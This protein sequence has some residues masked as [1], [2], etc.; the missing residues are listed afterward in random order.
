MNV[1]SSEN[2]QSGERKEI[3]GRSFRKLSDYETV[4]SFVL[5]LVA[6]DTRFKCRPSLDRILQ[7][8][9]KLVIVISHSSPLSWLPAPCLL[10]A[11][12]V[13]RGGSGRIPIGVM[14]RF[15]YSVPGL[16]ELAQFIGQSETPLGFDELLHHFQSLEKADLVV[17]PE[18]SNCFFGDPMEL[19]P[20]RSSRFVEIAIRTKTPML[21]CVHRGSESWGKTVPL[22]PDAVTKL[23]LPEMLTKFLGDRL[24]QT[25]LLTIPFPPQPM[26][27]FSM[28]CELYTPAT[29][30]LSDDPVMAKEQIAREAAL[31]HQRM[32]ELLTEIDDSRASATSPETKT[33]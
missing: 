27:L 19:Q 7:E 4:T 24:R 21:L 33:N 25:G 16:K 3:T 5:S 23:P 15:F 14:D 9:A 17:F 11:H 28:L 8:N 22:D 32:R 12:S 31:V 18:G 13:A 1:E 2:G 6:K 29:P 10:A 30:I 26:P 20:F